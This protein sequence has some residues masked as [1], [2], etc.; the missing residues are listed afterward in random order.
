MLQAEDFCIHCPWP[1]YNTGMQWKQWFR[2]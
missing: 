2:T 1:A